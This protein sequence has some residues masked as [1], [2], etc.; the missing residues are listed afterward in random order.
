MIS[1]VQCVLG[2]VPDAG[3]QMGSAWLVSPGTKTVYLGMYHTHSK[4]EL[5][6]Q[7]GG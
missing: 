7:S 5:A 3:Y 2:L 6:R 1:C 4:Q